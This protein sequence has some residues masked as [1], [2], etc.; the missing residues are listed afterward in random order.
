MLRCS[1][2]TRFGHFPG[3]PVYSSKGVN[4]DIPE[5]KLLDHQ[6]V[7]PGT[8]HMANWFSC[9]RNGG[10]PNADMEMGYKQ[11]IA[12]VMGDTAY[13]LGRK[14]LFDKEKREIRFH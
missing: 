10:R 9:I 6:P 7:Y 1:T 3:N 4:D 11:G 2:Q 12:I 8:A 14:V 13:R 5:Q